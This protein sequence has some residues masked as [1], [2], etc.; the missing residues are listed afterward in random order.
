MSASDTRT[1]WYILILT[2]PSTHSAVRIRV[3][4]T[5]KQLGCGILRDGVYLLPAHAHKETDLETV[6][7][8]VSAEGGIAHLL[9]T[10]SRTTAQEQQFIAMFDRQAEFSQ[11]HNDLRHARLTLTAQATGN[12]HKIGKRWQR[13]FIDLQKIDFFPGKAQQQ[14][15]HALQE[16]QQSIQRILSPGEPE[17]VQQEITRRDPAQFQQR[18]WATRQN[19]W[20][21]RLASAWLIRRFIDP[22]AHFLWLQD[23]AL[24]P[25]AAVGFDFD[26]AT[27]THTNHFVTFETLL[28]SFALDGNPSLCRLGLLVHALD[29]GETELPES[30]GLLRILEGLR[31]ETAHDDQLLHEAMRI[32]DALLHSFRL[33]AGQECAAANE[34]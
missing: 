4:R 3:W 32:F 31:Q 13:A 22:Q 24:C 30:A 11:L 25:P 15:A 1:H 17:T 20:I 14:A 23:I 18:C 28:L 2:L 19:L 21:D 8:Q 10:T 6:A 12:L 34:R 27:F 33:E 9:Y 7:E 16:L 29:T 5:L 26:G